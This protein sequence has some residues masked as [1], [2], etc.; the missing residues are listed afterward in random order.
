MSVLGTKLHLPSPRR[1]LVPRA[2]LTDR[3]RVDG[4]ERPRLVLVA[5]PAGFGKTTFLVQWL[6]AERLQRRVAWLA[7]DP[8]DADLRVFLTHLVAAIQTAEPEAGVDAL[9]LLEAGATTPTEAVLVSL[10]NDLDVLAG[11]MV[12]ALDDYHAID[13]PAVHEVVTFLLENLPPQ[14][15][16]AMATRAD[17]P[18]PLA[19]LR[20]RGELV[21]VRAA[22][23]R[24]TTDEAEV[25]LNEVMGLGLEPALVAALEARTE[26]W[27]T[28]LQLAA[29]SARTHAGAAG[30]SGDV[31]GFV[32]A[33]S[34]S[35]RFVLDYLVEEVLG[36]QRDEVRAFLLDTSVLDQLTG[37]LCDALTGRCDGQLMLETLERENLFVVALDDERRWYRYHHL[38]AD[39]LR[40]RLAARHGDRVGELHAAASRWLAENGLLV[41]AVR[42]AIASGDHEHTADLMELTVA[43]LRRRRQDRTFFDWLPALPDDVVRR[44]PLLAT[45]VGASRLSEGDFDG[46]EAWLDAAEAGLS[47]TQ[48]S[49]IP[50]AGSLA[51]A[52]RDREDEVRSLPALIA[53]YRASV[54]Q[55]RGDVE[56][57][58]AHARRALALAGPED[59]FP[60]GAA[61]G[62][63]GLAAW[64]AGDLD[65][66]VDTFTE[67][68]ASLHAAGM[69]ADELGAT[70]V[71]A[72]MWLARGRPVQARR[73][74]ERALAVAESHP[75]PALSSTGDLH[76]GLADVLRE[77]GDLDGAAEHLEVARELGDRASLLENRHRWYTAMAALLQATGD[78]DGAVAMLDQA[79]PLFLPGYFPDVR[80]IAST[81]AR[82]RI[83]QGRLDDARAWARERGIA[84][85]DPT[86]YLAEHNQL[87]LTR[88]LVAEGDAREA[89][90]LVDRVLEVARAAGRD[91]SV[92]EACLVR[93]LA[94]H[95]NG[96]ADAAAA[97]LAAAL[98]AGVPAGYC[99][100]FLDEGQ[101][102]AELLER[103]AR[104]RAADVRTH[105]DCLLAAAR[106]PLA[107]APA[108][109]VSE[110]G[111]SERERQ[112]LRLL[113]TELSGP[114]I[115]GELFVSVNTLRTH[116]KHI[117]SKLDVKTRRAAVRQAADLGLL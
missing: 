57:T 29:L 8:G 19:R 90:G 116:T 77:Q 48:L 80:P 56:G 98:I 93:A 107:T 46:V 63:I 96:D 38:F 50:T 58:V 104:A 33:F 79:E 60:R 41:D 109:R 100:L 20:A 39:A 74:Y 35:H 6:A 47:T 97:D 95:S 105:A 62:F 27:A 7:L 51:E 17:P 102:M 114:E 112:V 115:A 66:A 42:H 59:H 68:V 40:V 49:T 85:T 52:A 23:L 70:G 36:R 31:A 83:L 65:R 22:D 16:L 84:P 99:R 26:G 45:Y 2:R 106:R 75:G 61:A 24:F 11:S 55:A 5:A 9:V 72:N 67:A 101:P 76:V 12:V 108:G 18:L 88:L 10:L 81:R 86:S 103:A 30:G 92:I 111:L 110:E 117:F 89:L 14:I 69:V 53:V 87:T 82:A 32:Q 37:G 78:I 73:L 25:F 43:D 1:R 15:T 4:G 71:L 94:H 64:A 34:G 13:G 3:L 113:A 54:A 21:E 28:G 91:G 44:R